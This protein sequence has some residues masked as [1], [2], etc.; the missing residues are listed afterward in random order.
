MCTDEQDWFEGNVNLC[1]ST[2]SQ[3]GG[4]IICTRALPIRA[5]VLVASLFFELGIIRAVGAAMNGEGALRFL[6]LNRK[7]T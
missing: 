2:I 4:V 7:T 6:A 3:E 5:A 1:G